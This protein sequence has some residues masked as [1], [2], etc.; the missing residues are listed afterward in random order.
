[1]GAQPAARSRPARQ[2]QDSRGTAGRLSVTVPRMSD[3]RHA[4]ATL[5]NRDAILAVLQRILPDAVLPGAGPEPRLLLEIASGTGEHAAFM[6]AQLPGWTWQPSDYEADAAASIDA[7]A[8]QSGSSNIR[9]ALR[10]DTC[11]AD[12]PVRAADAILCCNMIHIAPWAAAEGLFRGAAR[13]LP[14]G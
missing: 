10:L 2:P 1:A 7:H 13:I 12:W 11:A 8:R 3:A 14:P 5:R 9:P 6:A 4:P